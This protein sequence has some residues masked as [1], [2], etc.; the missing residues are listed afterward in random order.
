METGGCNACDRR[1]SGTKGNAIGTQYSLAPEWHGGSCYRPPSCDAAQWKGGRL[2]A[3]R[4]DTYHAGVAFSSAS[5]D[6]G[7]RNLA[8][9]RGSRR[10]PGLRPEPCKG[11]GVF[12]GIFGS[13]LSAHAVLGQA[14]CPRGWMSRFGFTSGAY[15]ILI[16]HAPFSLKIYK[17]AN[18]C[19]IPI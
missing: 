7:I 10:P 16:E 13:E 14:R 11:S 5:A 8:P 15:S 18:C 12:H 19:I 2:S 3:S 17:H 6:E 1:G 4:R 9:I